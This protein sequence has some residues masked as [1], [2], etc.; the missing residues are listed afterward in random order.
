MN[1]I[2]KELNNK[3]NDLENIINKIDNINDIEEF[4]KIIGIGINDKFS[5]PNSY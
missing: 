1:N 2:Q 4:N 3:L 5:C